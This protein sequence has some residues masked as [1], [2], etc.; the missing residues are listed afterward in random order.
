MQRVN[1]KDTIMHSHNFAELVL[2]LEG[3]A[4]HK[5]AKKKMELH[6]GNFFIISG[7]TNHGYLNCKNLKLINVI[8]NKKFFIKF[9]KNF[10]NS[11]KDKSDLIMIQKKMK[12]YNVLNLNEI[13]ISNI[14]QI[15]NKIELEQYEFLTASNQ[16]LELLLF[17]LLILY[18]RYSK[19]EFIKSENQFHES[20]TNIISW[21]NENY[22]KEI[23]LKDIIAKAN[24]SR[25]NLFRL[26]K[27]MTGKTPIQYLLEIRIHHAM[28]KLRETSIPISEIAEDC[29]FHDQNYFARFF[30]KLTGVSP[31]DF[32]LGVSILAQ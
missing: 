8:I 13:Q 2:V 19:S 30:K 1:Q 20:F 24:T 29:G 17:Q 3:T 9:L 25:R 11:E 22:Q 27:K 21:I 10:T 32:R 28:H 31:K 7:N 12:H 14:M 18:I 4:M 23:S 26:F 15:I 5:I 16:M 6:R